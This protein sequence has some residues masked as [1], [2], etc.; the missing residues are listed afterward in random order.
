MVVIQN[1]NDGVGQAGEIIEKAGE[2]RGRR[3]Q[4][5]GRK[6]LPGRCRRCLEQYFVAPLGHTAK[7]DWDHHHIDPE[8]TRHNGHQ[9]IEI[10]MRSLLR[11]SHIPLKPT[12]VSSSAQLPSPLSVAH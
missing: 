2:Q 5:D 9:T 3:G 7:N 10:A 12:P 8:T 4:R 1:K 6:Q 11:S